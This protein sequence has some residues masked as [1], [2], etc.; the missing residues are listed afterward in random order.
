MKNL[1]LLLLSFLVLFSDKKTKVEANPPQ[2]ERI[3]H[4]SHTSYKKQGDIHWKLKEIPLINY[5]MRLLGGDLDIHTSSDINNLKN[6]DTLF[7]FSAP[8]TLWSVGNHD[9]TNRD[10]I[11]RFTERPLFYSYTYRDISFLVLDTEEKL[12]KISGEQLDLV[13][14][15]TKDLA[16]INHLIVL[17]HKLLWLQGNEALQDFLKPIPNGRP[18]DCDYCTNPN[19]FY[20]DVYPYLVEVQKRG[21]QVWCIAGDIGKNVNEFNYTLPEGVRLL[22]SGLNLKKKENKALVLERNYGEKNLSA[23]YVCIEDL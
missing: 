19:N 3:L 15:V 10:F 21:T 2:L 1:S 22:A 11:E 4:I 6:W 5:N 17:T 7:N 23:K 12:S 9:D 20:K 18:G 8:S 16:G 14:S 13:Q